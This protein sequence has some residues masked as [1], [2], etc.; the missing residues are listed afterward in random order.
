MRSSIPSMVAFSSSVVVMVIV[1][2]TADAAAVPVT[3][4]LVVALPNVDVVDNSR[5]DFSA[6][7]SIVP[8]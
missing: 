3:S 2:G 4:S 5:G 7:V 1:G 8:A 6:L